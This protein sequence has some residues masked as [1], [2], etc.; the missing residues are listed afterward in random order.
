MNIPQITNDIDSSFGAIYQKKGDYKKS[1]EFYEQYI[2][3]AIFTKDNSRA[4]KG[5]NILAQNYKNEGY[6]K[7]G[8]N[9]LNQAHT[10]CKYTSDYTLLLLTKINLADFNIDLGLFDESDKILADANDISANY[11]HREHIIRIYCLYTK[12]YLATGRINKAFQFAT[13]A[14]ESAMIRANTEK[15][16]SLVV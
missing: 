4:V 9:L 6:I 12:K 1:H 11:I 16:P 2:E 3:K 8:R 7:H 15:T 14:R 13:K 5:L 10:L